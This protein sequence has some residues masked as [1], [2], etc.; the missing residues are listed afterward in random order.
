[1]KKYKLLRVSGKTLWSV[2][3]LFA[4][5]KTAAQN[6]NGII[7]IKTGVVLTIGKNATLV[8]NTNINNSGTLINAGSIILNGNTV[9]TFPGTAG[10]IPLM[11]LLEVKNTGAGITLNQSIRI[12]KELKL[13][14]GNLALGNYDITIKSDAVQTAAVSAIGAGAGVSYGTGRFVIERFINVGTAGHGKSWQFLSVPSTGQTIKDSWQEAGAATVGYGTQITNPLGVAAGY[15]LTT[16]RTSIKTFVST[17]NSYDQGPASTTALIN[18]PKGYMLFV[19]GDRTVASGTGSVPTI[20]RIKGTLFTPANPPSSFTINSGQYESVGNPYASQIDYT[21]LTRT[22]GVDNTFYAWDPLLAGMYGVGG[23]QTISATNS[24]VSVPGGGNY[25][26]VHKNIESGQAFFVHST[27]APGTIGFTENAKTGGSRLLNRTASEATLTMN[28]QF[29]R[30][31]LLTNTGSM[32]DGNAGAFDSDLSNEV[33]T[34]DALKIMNG[35]ENFCLKRDNYLLAVEGR[36]LI[37]TTDTLFYFMNHL[38]QQAYT[39]LIVPQNMDMSKQAW[40]VDNFLQT[41]TALSLSDSNYINF[42]V[43][44][45]SLSSQTDRFKIVFN[46]ASVL[47]ISTTTLNAVRNV[48]GTIGVNWKTTAEN[49]IREYIVEK[50]ADGRIFNTITTKNALMNNGAEANYGFNDVLPFDGNN[51]YRIKIVSLNGEVKYSNV[52]KLAPLKKDSDISV[53]PNPITG[54]TLNLNFTTQF[55]GSY[56]IV[57]I[58]EAGQK[59]WTSRILCNGNSGRKIR[60]EIPKN[61]AAGNYHLTLLDKEGRSFKI[62][63]MLL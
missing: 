18:N 60:L 19:R 31:T 48:D 46:T 35:G 20:L 47:G 32:A 9:Q 26:G 56:K 12:D 24:W 29:I 21:L 28:R 5:F 62:A 40:L 17:T 58:N 57:L 63:L 13:T 25:A 41:Q 11:S 23:Y 7:I 52:V 51:F 1:M 45:N 38:L 59:I 43:T 10:S 54:R 16:G 2:L 50:S 4:F 6:P 42:T 53:Y 34:D 36:S 14:N 22:G 30:S 15:D 3:I 44:N 49:N 61:I 8:T 39:I 33:N 55:F 37:A 27:S